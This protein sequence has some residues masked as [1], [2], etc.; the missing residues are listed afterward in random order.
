M[1]AVGGQEDRILEKEI[2]IS[3][4]SKRRWDNTIVMANEELSIQND[5]ATSHAGLDV[6]SQKKALE[7]RLSSASEELIKLHNNHAQADQ[8]AKSL[9]AQKQA[10]NALNEYNLTFAETMAS[11]ELQT[12]LLDLQARGQTRAVT[13]AEI[14]LRYRI[15]IADALARGNKIRASDL[16]KQMESNKLTEAIREYELGPKGRSRE[17]LDERHAAQEA[18]IIESRNRERAK[19]QKQADQHNFNLPGDDGLKSGGLISGS[20][21]TGK[22]LGSGIE[23]LDK[24]MAAPGHMGAIKHMDKS[25]T[26]RHDAAQKQTQQLGQTMVQLMQTIVQSLQQ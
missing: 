24:K 1:R 4:I 19:D 15:Q 9:A 22:L 5:L 11:S 6:A 20:L 2:E 16:A 21:A 17:T 26:N 23:E 18:R 10:E 25:A 3:Q 12:K 7:D 14:E 8:L 13:Q